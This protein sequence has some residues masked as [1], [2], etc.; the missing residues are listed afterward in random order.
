MLCAGLIVADHVCAPIERIPPAGQLAMT[1]RIDL[2]IGGCASNV[3][4]DLS[5]LGLRACVAGRVGEDALGRHVCSALAAEGADCS[6]VTFSTM[7]QT[8][9]TMVVN[10][11]GK[12]DGSFTPWERMPSSPA[13]RLMRPRFV[14]AVRSTS[15]D[16]D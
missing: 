8:A 12:T 6:Q 14:A 10:V 13:R 15:V 11:R 4:V 9:T 16:S 2:T 3:A 5:R 7:S 1:E